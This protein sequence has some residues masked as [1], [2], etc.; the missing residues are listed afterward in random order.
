MV[1][2]LLKDKRVILFLSFLALFSLVILASTVRDATFRPARHFSQ[3]E[4]EVVR[5]PVGQMIRSISKIPLERQIAF[6]VLLFLFAVLAIS[7]LSPE[8]RKKLLKQLFRWTVSVVLILYLLR[9]KPD[10]L[11][12]LFP[13]LALGGQS[14]SSATE[15][16]APPVFEP[17]HVSGWLS[18]FIALGIVLL[19]A[20]F[21]WRVNRWRMLRKE[22]SEPHQL[23]EIA[24][25]ARAS[26][27]DLSS[28]QGSAQDTIIQCYSR[29]ESGSGCATRFIS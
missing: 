26:L 19:I 27:T 11:A 8:T 7:L 4:S 10:L 28:G 25:I 2:R 23:D 12:G 17:P 9:I 1:K 24:A 5:I 21:L 20:A 22:I 29:Y 18:F 13:N 16:T 14:A 15:G 6:L 3:E